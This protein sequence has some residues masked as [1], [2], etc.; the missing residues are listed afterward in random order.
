M[1]AILQV[2]VRS[3]PLFPPFDDLLKL[4][5]GTGIPLIEERGKRQDAEFFVQ[6]PPP[7]DKVYYPLS[8]IPIFEKRERSG[9]EK[10]EGRPVF[11][12]VKVNRKNS[13]GGTPK[14]HQKSEFKL[15]ESSFSG[16]ILA[17]NSS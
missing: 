5:C 2:V 15:P 4:F 14:S 13:N 12:A 8:T 3:Q 1:G 7:P 16:A 9:G 6:P 10:D 11:L 17:N